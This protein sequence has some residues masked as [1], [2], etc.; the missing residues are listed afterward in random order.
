MHGYCTYECEVNDR[1]MSEAQLKE[2]KEF[3]QF[4]FEYS[5]KIFCVSEKFME[6][7]KNNEPK[8]ADKF[9]YNYNGVDIKKIEKNICKNDKKP[10]QI[11]SLGGGIPQKKNLLVCR[12]INQLNKE[13]NMNLKY[14]VIGLPDKDKEEIC[15]YDFV[16][17]YD[18]L[19]NE[20]VINILGESQIYIQNSVLETFGLSIIEALLSDCNLLISNN[21][22]AIS[23]LKTIRDS[24]LI[25]DTTDINEISKKIEHL[26]EYNNVQRLKVGLDA[27]IIDYT[28]ASESLYKKILNIWREK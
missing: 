26:I 15:S 16:T 7:M 17:Y 11:V 24:D 21:I 22:G 14:I 19:T 6:F 1:K 8:Y 13:K 2:I 28:A 10:N 12:A 20:H 4:I 18:R 27:D 3:E 25:Y 5:D 9:D 23:V